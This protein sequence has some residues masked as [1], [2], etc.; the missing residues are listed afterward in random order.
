MKWLFRTIIIG[1]LILLSLTG[2][3][4]DTQAELILL[5]IITLILASTGIFISRKTE[6][7]DE[8]LPSLLI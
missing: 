8:S 7:R 5:V 3:G 2:L 6:S 4:I 1:S